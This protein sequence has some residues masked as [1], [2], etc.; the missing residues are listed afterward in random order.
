MFHLPL[1]YLPYPPICPS[2]L[3]FIYLPTTASSPVP[4]A[5]STHHLPPHLNIY[6]PV[7]SIF[8]STS[9]PLTHSFINL[10]I[11]HAHPPIIPFPASYH[12]ALTTLPIHT[13]HPH[14]HLPSLPTLLRLPGRPNLADILAGLILTEALGSSRG[15]IQC[16]VSPPSSLHTLVSDKSYPFP[17]CQSPRAG[18]TL[19]I[20]PFHTVPITR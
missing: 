15:A 9:L 16:C 6:P 14:T 18:P 12:T 13:V 8:L 10:P 7:H 19:E 4:P 3:L 1:I 2:T 5:P 17:R 11:P 20:T